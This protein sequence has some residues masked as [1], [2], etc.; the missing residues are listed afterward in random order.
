[1]GVPM[2]LGTLFGGFFRE[3][4]ATFVG[5]GD[6]PILIPWETLVWFGWPGSHGTGV[7]VVWATWVAGT[8]F[9]GGFRLPLRL[10][11]R[12][13]HIKPDVPPPLVVSVVFWQVNS[14]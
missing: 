3:T 8:P 14:N 10:N 11:H 6:P 9:L 5:G 4:E 2:R 13:F 12:S 1:M 7:P